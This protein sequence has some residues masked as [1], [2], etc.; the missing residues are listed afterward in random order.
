MSL[1]PIYDSLDVN[2]LSLIVSKPEEK[3]FN[4]TMEP[5]LDEAVLSNLSS[6]L[7]MTVAL[8]LK[9]VYV[10]QGMLRKILQLLKMWGGG[11]IGGID[12]SIFLL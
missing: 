10:T 7:V 4:L 2:I 6:V 12:Q 1:I 5:Y 11:E 8:I 9:D 3:S